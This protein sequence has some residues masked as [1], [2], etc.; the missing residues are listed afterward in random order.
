MARDRINSRREPFLLMASS[1]VISLAPSTFTIR[2]CR[3]YLT[4]STFLS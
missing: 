2:I 3:I 1:I 4:A